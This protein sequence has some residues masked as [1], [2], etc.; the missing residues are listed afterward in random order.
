MGLPD[1]TGCVS[2]DEAAK[3]LQIDRQSLYN[4]A[5]SR[6]GFP[7]PVKVGRT[8]LWQRAELEAWLVEHPPRPKSR[9]RPRAE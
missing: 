5:S 2:S 9:H 3:L 4:L 7:R 6:A 8:S 1:L